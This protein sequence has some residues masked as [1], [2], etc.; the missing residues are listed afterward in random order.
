MQRPNYSSYA[1]GVPNCSRTGKHAGGQSESMKID[2]KRSKI[3]VPQNIVNHIAVL[4]G[5]LPMKIQ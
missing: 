3:L 4:F 5:G 1:Q 2:K